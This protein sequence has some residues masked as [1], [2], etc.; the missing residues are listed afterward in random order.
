[1]YR[2]LAK[3]DYGQERICNCIQIDILIDQVLDSGKIVL[4]HYNLNV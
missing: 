4:R 3:D 2:L 1:M